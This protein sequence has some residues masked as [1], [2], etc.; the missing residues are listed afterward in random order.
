MLSN[1]EP[2]GSR[3]RLLLTSSEAALLLHVS[4]KTLWNHTEPRG[5]R[6][7]VV[8]FGKT[9]RYSPAAIESWI[10]EQSRGTSIDAAG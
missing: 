1:D 7:P 3:P 8:R 4:E 2:E 9:L 5:N 10:A 6:I